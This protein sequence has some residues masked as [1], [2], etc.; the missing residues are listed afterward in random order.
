MLSNQWSPYV[1]RFACGWHR[2]PEE[3]PPGNHRPRREPEA[4]IPVG[5]EPPFPRR[6][7]ERAPVRDTSAPPPAG[8]PPALLHLGAPVR[9]LRP[10]RRWSGRRR[11]AGS[12]E[13]RALS[14]RTRPGGKPAARARS[15]WPAPECRAPW[16]GG[17]PRRGRDGWPPVRP[18]PRPD[19]SH[20]PAAVFRTEE[21]TSLR[22]ERSPPRGAPRS[23]SPPW[24]RRARGPALAIP[25]TSGRG[26]LGQE[27]PRI[28]TGPEPPRS[29]GAGNRRTS[30]RALPRDGRTAGRL[31]GWPPRRA[32]RR[33]DRAATLPCRRT[34]TGVGTACR[35]GRP[36]RQRR[37]RR[38]HPFAD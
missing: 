18:G 14:W 22:R 15:A 10:W 20:G 34:R 17:T 19:R 24:L 35:T 3:H 6:S 1:G 12:T 28:R 5:P 33:L 9:R 13:G 29:P 36:P 38:R 16:P 7:S 27:V 32:P 2:L 26:W 11:P 8:P 21:P 30:P 31:A 23:G 37:Q 4:I 25:R